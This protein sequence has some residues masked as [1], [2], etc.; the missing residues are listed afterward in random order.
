MSDPCF[1]RE[2]ECNLSCP[3]FRARTIRCHKLLKDGCIKEYE[4]CGENSTFHVIYDI[5]FG[6][7]GRLVILFRDSVKSG[8]LDAFLSMQQGVWTLTPIS[9]IPFNTTTNIRLLANGI[10][11]DIGSIADI[12]WKYNG[13]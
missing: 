3:Y 10:I 2:H 7:V 13:F 9:Q 8:Y 1:Y 4:G 11:I 6:S 12:I 5:P